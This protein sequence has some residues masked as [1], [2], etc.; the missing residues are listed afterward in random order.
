MARHCAHCGAA[1]GERGQ[2][3]HRCGAP[4][5]GRP[6]AS[7]T[8][9]AAPTTVATILP[10][11]VAGIALLSLLAF[12]VGQNFGRGKAPAAVAAGP[13]AGPVAGASA[14]GRAPDISSM[15]PQERADR[16]FQRVMTYVSE[17]KSDSVTF[18]APMAI[19][20]F[21]ALAPLDAHQRYDLGLLGLVSGDGA[22]AR[23]QADTILA[24]NASHL[25]GLILG[26]RAAGLQ[27]DAAARADFVR[28]LS[29][30]LVSERAKGLQEYQD[31]APDIDAAVREA[32]GRTP[33]PG[34]NR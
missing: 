24:N 8:G 29:T 3:C 1:L 27:S 17:G 6:V 22:L 18:F 33:I 23:A 11:A 5:D 14:P 7:S 4:R 32:D 20:S 31:H 26:M 28:R 34:Q 21:E 2:F 12:I 19:Q 9:G 16:L 25:L 30:A 10:W 13:V 15:S